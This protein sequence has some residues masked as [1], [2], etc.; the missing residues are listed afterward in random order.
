MYRQ[1]LIIAKLKTGKRGQVKSIQEAKVH[2][3]LQCHLRRRRR[4]RRGGGGGGGRRRRGEEEEEKEDD[5]DGEGEESEEE[6]GEGESK[7][8]RKNLILMFATLD[9]EVIAS[10]VSKQGTFLN[11]M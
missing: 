11:F 3:G 1:I 8:K 4:R 7:K 10:N 5:D 2:S 9:S 6:G